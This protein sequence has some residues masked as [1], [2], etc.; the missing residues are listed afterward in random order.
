VQE[1]H[2]IACAHAGL[3]ILVWLGTSLGLVL[4]AAEKKLPSAPPPPPAQVQGP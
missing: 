2:T 4:D 3:Y 1:T